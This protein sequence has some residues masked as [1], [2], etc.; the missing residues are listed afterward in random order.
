ML[1][2]TFIHSHVVSVRTLHRGK[3]GAPRRHAEVAVP[4][5]V[6]GGAQGYEELLG[7]QAVTRAIRAGTSRE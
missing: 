3:S 5:K 6:R 4:P 1:A 7:A 2:S